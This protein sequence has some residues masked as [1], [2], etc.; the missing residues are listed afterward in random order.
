M[1]SLKL[2]APGS[3]PCMNQ[4]WDWMPCRGTAAAHAVNGWERNRRYT[5]TVHEQPGSMQRLDQR[6]G[7]DS[8]A[9][10]LL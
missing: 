1:A 2:S 4:G 7:Q 5:L 6:L 10:C 3:S 8:V 9:L